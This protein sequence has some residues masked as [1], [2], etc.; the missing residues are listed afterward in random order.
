MIE[1]DAMFKP[2]RALKAGEKVKIN[3]T[4]YVFKP[5]MVKENFV[6]CPLAAFNPGNNGDFITIMHKPLIGDVRSHNIDRDIY[7]SS[8]T[9]WMIR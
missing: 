4:D 6:N 7:W 3:G 9:G 1:I 5:D 8:V 2:G